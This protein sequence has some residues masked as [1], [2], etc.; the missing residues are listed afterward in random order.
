ML[1][2][3]AR[4]N[5]VATVANGGQAG[6][7]R[8]V[9]LGSGWA[10][11]RILKTIDTSK[12]DVTMVSARNHFLFTPL[13]P[14]SS[15]GTLEFRSIS[16]PVRKLRPEAT[17]FQAQCVDID[18]ANNFVQCVSDAK[19]GSKEFTIPFDKLVIAIGQDVSTFGIK[20]VKEHAF[21]MKEL[22]DARRLRKRLIELFEEA[23]YPGVSDEEKKRLLRFVFVGGGP[24][25]VETAAEVHDLVTQ[26]MK[27]SYPAATPF[28]S[29]K[30][31]EARQIL[32]G[33]DEKL[34][35]YAERV[36]SRHHI[37][38]IKG[39]VKEVGPTHVLV[40]YGDGTQERID[41][42]LVLWT[43]GVT[44]RELLKK[45]DR[46][47]ASLPMDERSR[48]LTDGHLRVKDL[49][50]VFALGD[51]SQIEGYPLPATAQAAQQEAKFLVKYLNDGCPQKARPFVFNNMGMLAYLG[52][53][54]ALADVAQ[55]TVTGRGWFA[56]LFWRSAYL[57]RLVSIR[58]KVAV[59]F[60]WFKTFFFGRDTS[61]LE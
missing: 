60:D 57:T 38:I 15:V 22:A 2:L 10:G 12:Y 39:S 50:N 37:D 27:K 36:F 7:E 54:K 3:I 26:D 19:E 43:A 47:V 59:P 46:A 24:T 44:A 8:L 40:E 35:K 28:V 32:T 5:F 29:M 52:G 56:W 21:F 1:S 45:R 31:V 51:C 16:E 25:G 58:N 33:F 48:I 23:S 4:R 61:R 49:D 18:A 34:V 6:R 9:I 53:Y 55:H 13:L 42:G 11:C 20:G 41:C 30:L 17:F 14:S